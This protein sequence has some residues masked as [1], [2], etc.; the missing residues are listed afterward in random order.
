MRILVYDYAMRFLGGGQ[1]I[2]CW[3]ASLLSENHEVFL[4]DNDRIPKGNLETI[5][6]VDL[7]RTKMLN[8]PTPE[9]VSRAT[10][11]FDI[12]IN[13]EHAHWVEPKAKRNVMICHFP[14]KIDRG[15]HKEKYDKLFCNSN[16]GKKWIKKWWDLDAEVLYPFTNFELV[17]NDNR[18]NWILSVSRITPQKQQIKMIEIFKRLN[19]Q[20]PGWELIIAGATK[21]FCPGWYYKE[22]TEAIEGVTL[23]FDVPEEKIKELYSKSK[24][25]W[26]LCGMGVNEEKEPQLLEHFGLVVVEAMRSGCVPIVYHGGGHTDIIT[27]DSGVTFFTETGLKERTLD[28][29]NNHYLREYVT[30]N[31]QKRSEYFS[32][33]SF[34]RRVNRLIE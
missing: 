34:R 26:H 21:G 15:T 31:A 16:Y 6:G 14:L 19:P 18:E 27:D 7:S 23:Y 24:I 22:L 28:Y 29:A 30:D 10:Q 20:L 8:A 3:I 13:A 11:G 32:L 33:C 12:F 17:N 1:R 5:Y 4:V 25:F 9:K 2:A